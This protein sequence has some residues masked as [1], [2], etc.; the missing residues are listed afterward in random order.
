MPDSEYYAALAAALMTGAY[1]RHVD[2]YDPVRFPRDPQSA[3][4]RIA[5][6]LKEGLL[7]LAHRHGFVRVRPGERESQAEFLTEVLS[8]SEGLAALYDSLADEHSRSALIKI[9]AFRALGNQRVL[10]P[11][12]EAAYRQQA[13]DFARAG[14]AVNGVGSGPVPGNPAA[15][16][17]DDEGQRI[18]L[19]A[20]PIHV[21][22]TFLAHQYRYCGDTAEVAVR[23]GDTVLDGGGCL[24]DTALYFARRVGETGRV[25]TCEF[26][27]ENL[28]ILEA[29]LARNPALASRVKLVRGALWDRSGV[30]LEFENAGPATKVGAATSGTSRVETRT[31]DDLVDELQLPRLDFIKLDIEGAELPTLR[32]AERTL[33]RFHPRLAV[34]L[35]HSLDEFVTIPAYLRSLDLGYRF[36]LDHFTSHL[37]ETILF[38]TPGDQS[39]A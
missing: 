32:G 17:L 16:D 15:F 5:R 7:A 3:L 36:Y 9:L 31:I 37:E 19:V 24:G 10:L 29:N 6:N 28:P 13:V 21:V 39:R 4:G 33:A 26:D 8:R 27:S 1:D 2:N 35:Y 14:R 20:H 22:H 18:D 30:V 11:R 23:E 25:L 12:G 34:A 38:A